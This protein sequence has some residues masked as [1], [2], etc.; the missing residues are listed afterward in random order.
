LFLL[1]HAPVHFHVCSM[2]CFCLQN[3]CQPH[4]HLADRVLTSGCLFISQQLWNEILI[5]L[6]ILGKCIIIETLRVGRWSVNIC[7]SRWHS[8]DFK[9]WSA[10]IVT[11]WR[12]RHRSYSGRRWCWLGW[13][14]TPA[15]APPACQ[16]ILHCTISAWKAAISQVFMNNSRVSFNRSLHLLMVWKN[17]T[18]LLLF[19][20]ISAR[21]LDEIL[22]FLNYSAWK[23]SF[24]HFRLIQ[25]EAHVGLFYLYLT[26]LPC[27]TNWH[28][29]NLQE[30]SCGF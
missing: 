22:R 6:A 10:R 8:F 7:I 12:R 20:D 3:G 16:G 30:I 11:G 4:Y 19:S 18:P 2:C 17:N 28:V 27:H 23:P 1:I 15:I 13:R 24:D 14:C 21:F 5:M 9:H 29:E 25:G 26:S